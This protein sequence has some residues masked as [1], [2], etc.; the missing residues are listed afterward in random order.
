M[1]GRAVA[2]TRYGLSRMA[3]RRLVGRSSADVSVSLR[4]RCRMAISMLS[5]PV[6]RHYPLFGVP[7]DM[8]MWSTGRITLLQCLSIGLISIVLGICTLAVSV[9]PSQLA[10]LLILAVLCPFLA[11]IIGNDPERT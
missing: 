11:M 3:F 2:L 5:D 8:L 1:A 10:P 7:V 6:G 4:T 9:L